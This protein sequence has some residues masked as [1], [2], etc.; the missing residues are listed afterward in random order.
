[1]IE[2]SVLI[3]ILVCI[4]VL[5]MDEAVPSIYRSTSCGVH[6]IHLISAIRLRHT[7]RH[8]NAGAAG[9]FFIAL[10]PAQPLPSVGLNQGK[11]SQSQSHCQ[12]QGNRQ[13]S[14]GVFQSFG[15]HVHVCVLTAS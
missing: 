11:H 1:M 9:Q 8:V 12:Q 6:H 15:G 14:R 5:L 10:V 2:T 4:W 7:M 3:H 13:G